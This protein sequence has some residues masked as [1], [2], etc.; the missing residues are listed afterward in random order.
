M[1]VLPSRFNNS[2]HIAHF[3]QI[4]CPFGELD[5][6]PELGEKI[7]V[8]I[9]KPSSEIISDIR[10]FLCHKIS[11]LTTCS[12]SFWG[13]REVEYATKT[14]SISKT[15]CESAIFNYKIKGPEIFEHPSSLCI[16]MDKNTVEKEVITVVDHPVHLD[17]YNMELVDTIFI[18]GHTNIFEPLFIHDSSYWI[19]ESPIQISQSCPDFEI[20]TGVLY[21]TNNA[22]IDGFR[23]TTR[24]WT[25]HFRTFSFQDV[26]KMNFCNKTGIKFPNN[27]W[28][29]IRISNSI[30]QNYQSWTHSLPTCGTPEEINLPKYRDV[31]QH[32]VESILGIFFHSKCV[33]TVSRLRNKQSITPFDLSF[34]AQSH[35]GKG[36][37]Y[38]L[39]PHGLES[40]WTNYIRARPLQNHTDKN[41][42]G[43][44]TSGELIKFHDWYTIGNIIHGPNG[45]IQKGNVTLFPPHQS[46]RS[47]IDQDITHTIDHSRIHVKIPRYVQNHQ[48]ISVLQTHGPTDRVNVGEKITE[49]IT[50]GFQ[51]VSNDW[52]N[53]LFYGIITLTLLCIIVP[54]LKLIVMR[55]F[56]YLVCSAQPPDQR[57]IPLT[58]SS[59]NRISRPTAQSWF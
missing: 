6:P 35:P 41:V 53:Y 14:V 33:E 55:F 46:L 2:W 1:I 51:H 5:V 57:S 29:K 59:E 54:L 23:P 56:D 45:I 39:G 43:E 42:I 9:M 7:G 26:C 48:D 44:T 58:H 50:D 12:F 13:T 37:A 31:E 15:E 32:T 30:S 36:L 34:L 11:L 25:N 10:G 47:L 19:S 4:Q 21:N 20:Y 27:E 49:K 18:N 22:K 3:D 16:W 52:Q 17:P 28:L 8:E 24:L 38:R 40:Q